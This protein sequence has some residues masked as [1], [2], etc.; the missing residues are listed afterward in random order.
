ML[1]SWLLLPQ[2]PKAA[3]NRSGNPSSDGTIEDFEKSAFT[4]SFFYYVT[5]SISFLIDR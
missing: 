4:R 3:V 5:R 1:L 2:S